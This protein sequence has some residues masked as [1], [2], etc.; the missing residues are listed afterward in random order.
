MCVKT[1]GKQ[2]NG[3]E[4][5]IVR[6]NCGSIVLAGIIGLIGLVQ[7]IAWAVP[8]IKIAPENESTL[9]GTPQSFVVVARGSWALQYQW[10]KDGQPIN[11]ATSWFY[12]VAAV[13]QADDGS[14]FSVKV[15]DSSGAVTT[16]PVELK[17]VQP[18][19]SPAPKLPSIPGRVF[20]ATASG[21]AADGLTD[22]SLAI[23]K[24]INDAAAAGGGIVEFPPAEKPYMT[25][26]FSMASKIDLDIAKG[27]TLEVLPKSSPVGKPTAYPGDGAGGRA[28]V[29]TSEP[30]MHD[31]AFTGG[32]NIDG[33]GDTW[34]DEGGRRPFLIRFSG[35]SEVLV[36]GLTF[37]DPPMFHISMSNTN[38]LTVFGITINTPDGTPNTDGVDPSGAHQL[39]QNCNISCGDDNI[40]VK[41]G[42]A[43][44]TDL[45]IADCFFG[46]GHGVSVGG[47]SNRG[48]DG[49]IVKDCVFNGTTSGLR[50]KADPTQG[51]VCQNITY[52]N[53]KMTN[54]EYPI[55]F[56]SY[57]RSVGGPGATSGRTQSTIEK[58]KRW[59]EQ[60][61]NSLASSTL[62]AWRNI[63]I[64]NLVST[65][66][67]GYC[68]IYGLPLAHHYIDGV[69]LHDVKIEGGA[70]F[71]IYDASNIQFTGDTHIENVLTY[72]SL[73]V[74]Q[75]PKDQTVAIG[76]DATFEVK[77]V[78]ASGE[79]NTPPNYQWR[80]NG[81]PLAD[82]AKPDGAVISGAMTRS[83]KISSVQTAE[84]GKYAVTVTNSLDSFDVGT[85]MLVP[86]SAPVSATS[87]AANL[88]LTSGK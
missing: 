58:A 65:G 26:P 48:L 28:G 30:G 50:L 10:N 18:A 38:N 45:T 84:V 82:G 29:I 25:G 43:F 71:E 32:G 53:L 37:V 74:V 11:G 64:N 86:D 79:K 3:G 2:F 23:Q 76:D 55:V 59:N 39:I 66:S 22:N 54:V 68:V 40:A 78:G 42:S 6:K 44:C 1:F 41:A 15:S 80:F 21:V 7:G 5:H 75:Q 52:S 63:R 19:A 17:V 4:E 35:N 24:A 51:G 8:V 72:N 83:L 34:W 57:Y 60:P 12:R 61:P 73:A 88:S 16:D 9:L 77:V 36:S 85:K 27:A 46:T 67:K 20:D 49:M 33:E 62:P 47:Q 70:G 31:M 14:L 69:D 87:E 81:S 13:T 56:Y